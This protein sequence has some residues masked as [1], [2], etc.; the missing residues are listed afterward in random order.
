MS[1]KQPIINECDPLMNKTFCEKEVLTFEEAGI[2][3]RD[4]N[5]DSSDSTEEFDYEICLKSKEITKHL[6]KTLNY[7]KINR[8]QVKTLLNNIEKL[9]VR[10][11]KEK[12][13]RCK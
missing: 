5:T 6:I 10:E 12:K 4:Y 7:N 13:R 9:I 1:F 8:N 2:K 3:I 11:K